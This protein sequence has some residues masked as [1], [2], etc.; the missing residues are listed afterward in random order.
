M[1]LD[2]AVTGELRR[3]DLDLKVVA[4][5]GGVRDGQL[6]A[7]KGSAKGGFDERL[8]VR[9]HAEKGDEVKSSWF[10]ATRKG[11]RANIGSELCFLSAC[12]AQVG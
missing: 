12:I 5:A 2:H 1:L 7:G 3:S 9:S 6:R 8:H 4:T 11:G 10:A